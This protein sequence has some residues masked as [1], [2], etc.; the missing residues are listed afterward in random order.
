MF[1]YSPACANHNEL[2]LC[3]AGMEGLCIACEWKKITLAAQMWKS[4]LIEI[5]NPES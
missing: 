3:H 4:R 1:A 2:H 5:A